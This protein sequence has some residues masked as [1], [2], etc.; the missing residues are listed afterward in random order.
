MSFRACS[1][2][3]SVRLCKAKSLVK[4]GLLDYGSRDNGP[5]LVLDQLRPDKNSPNASGE[6]ADWLKEA[7]MLRAFLYRS[8]EH[9]ADRLEQRQQEFRMPLKKARDRYATELPGRTSFRIFDRTRR[10]MPLNPP[11]VQAEASQSSDVDSIPIARSINP[12]DA[13]GFT[14]FPPRKFPIESRV[15]DV[16][17]R[18]MRPRQGFWTRDFDQP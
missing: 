11:L 9:S 12:V 14:G 5:H 15:L 2:L 17:G 18:E 4:S 6:N 16:V 13:V 8:P 10:S 7:R 3:R 1:L